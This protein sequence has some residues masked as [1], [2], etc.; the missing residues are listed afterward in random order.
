MTIS[1]ILF[2]EYKKHKAIVWLY[3]GACVFVSVFS[4]P[5]LTLISEAA[6]LLTVGDT[7]ASLTTMFMGSSI[8]N[9]G[10]SYANIVGISCEPFSA[11]IFI[12]AIEIINNLCGSPLDIATTPMSNIFVLLTLVVF[13]VISKIMKANEATQIFGMIT[14]GELEKYLGLVFIMVLG[15]Y[16]VTGVAQVTVQA[17]ETAGVFETS[18]NVASVV[19][20]TVITVLMAIVSVLIFFVVKTVMFGLEVL[21]MTLSF[22]PGS[23]FVFETAKTV[24]VGVLIFVNTVFPEIG[25]ILNCIT[26]FICALLFKK[27]YL[28]SRYF[29]KIYVKPLLRRLKGFDPQISLFAKHLP[30]KIRKVYSSKKDDI[31]FLIPAYPV[32]YL[33]SEKV[34]RYETWFFIGEEGTA[35]FVKKRF[36]KKN[37]QTIKCED[38]AQTPVYIRNGFRFIEIFH[39]VDTEENLKKKFPKKEYSFVISKEYHYKFEEITRLSG[40]TDYAILQQEKKDIKM[41]RKEEKRMMRENKRLER[42]AKREAYLLEIQAKREAAAL[43][44]QRIKMIEANNEE[45]GE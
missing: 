44:K 14:L 25:F 20:N 39:Y 43:E 34:V 10:G 16:N 1:Q 38:T 7:I 40:L 29:R 15:I 3:I 8:K 22:I 5:F 27:C 23:G 37:L 21:Q 33:G 32:K 30:R 18:Y 17:A 9:L 36:A 35:G 6:E 42:E 28:A 11:L 19:F 26:L 2:Q 41:A 45:R 31:T 13:F 24:F 12:G 4:G